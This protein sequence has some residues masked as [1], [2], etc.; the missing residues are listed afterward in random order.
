MEPLARSDDAAAHDKSG[1]VRV[2]LS[3]ARA[4]GRPH[5]SKLL[6]TLAFVGVPT[7]VIA[8]TGGWHTIAFWIMTLVWVAAVV[9]V[10]VL[11]LFTLFMVLS[12]ILLVLEKVVSDR[13]NAIAAGLSRV[14]VVMLAAGAFAFTAQL[15]D[16]SD[17]RLPTPWPNLGALLVISVSAATAYGLWSLA[18]RFRTPKQTPAYIRR[19]SV[20]EPEDEYWSNQY[21]VG[22]RSWNWDGSSLRGV[23]ARW[24]SE[25]LEATCPHCDVV[26]SWEHAC[27]IYAAKSPAD[28]HRFYGGASIVGRVEMWGDVIEH[29]YG[30]RS[31]HARITD[32]W[33]GDPWR[34]ERI[35]DAYPAMNVSVG[36]PYASQGVDR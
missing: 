10:T 33:V 23:Y 8:G 35:H 28:I 30:Y 22:W 5:I 21:A 6:Y 4:L 18:A 11:T 20:P 26:P 7:A 17:V 27:G 29:E 32:L 24:P 15:G 1:R 16:V 12:P 31:S 25:V 34:A 2:A 13:A 36:S 14:L 9:Y 19:H 3:S